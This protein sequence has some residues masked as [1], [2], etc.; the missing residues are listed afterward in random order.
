MNIKLINSIN[1]IENSESINLGSLSLATVLNNAGYQTEIIDIDHF[2]RNKII[3]YSKN[4]N[5]M[6]SYIA[7]YIIKDNPQ[8]ISFYTM[9]N[10]YIYT[11]EVCKLIK[12][13]KQDIIIILGG[14]QATLT[15]KE[16]LIEYPFID[17]IGLGEGENSII[18]IIQEC[19]SSKKFS[20]LSGVAFRQEN[21]IIINPNKKLIKNLDDLPV[22]DYSL[23]KNILNT[24]S[25]QIDV[26]RGCPYECTYCVTSLFWERRFRL[27]TSRR[28]IAEMNMLY[29]KYGTT[30]FGLNHDLFTA[31]REKIINFCN[32]LTENQYSFKW[33]CSARLDTLDEELIKIMGKAGCNSMYLGIETG[34]PRMQS[35]IKKRL[36]LDDTI[37]VVESLLKNNIKLTTSFIY[38]FPNETINDSKLTLD[39]IIK[40]LH[41]KGVLI[42]LHKL[43]TFPGS[44]ITNDIEKKLYLSTNKTDLVSSNISVA[45]L[46]QVLKEARRSKKIHSTYYNFDTKIRQS[47]HSL[48]MCII[49]ISTI[50]ESYSYT[51]SKLL[52][53]YN[54]NL[55]ELYKDNYMEFNKLKTKYYQSISSLTNIKSETLIHDSFNNII[56]KLLFLKESNVLEKVYDFETCLYQFMY[57]SKDFQKIVK[58]PINVI[59]LIKYNE[60]NDNKIFQPITIR[61]KRIEK[62]KVEVKR[63]A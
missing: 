20:K 58:Y 33:S 8:I 26:G 57:K 60:S 51:L 38:G 39:L 3:K 42:Q 45:Y 62:S 1:F 21:E 32:D 16:T 22:I 23:A 12:E 30:Q 2:L 47:F 44:N 34:S 61:L 13:M 6:F 56:N 5:L 31:S 41:F 52:R 48:D 7:N 19:F 53:Y 9:C 46:P 49:V 27:K 24:E 43:T 59:R 55:I 40:I 11:L 36:P 17:L 4:F 35:L 50:R 15:A 28:I 10:S 63:I 54:N 37:K 18:P 29:E 14:P 25:I